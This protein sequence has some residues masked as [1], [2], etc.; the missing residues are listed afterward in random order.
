MADLGQI[1]AWQI[2]AMVF[3]FSAYI[4]NG[5]LLQI[6]DAKSVL[7]TSRS[8]LRPSLALLAAFAMLIVIAVGT[9]TAEQF[10]RFWFFS[11][12]ATSAVLIATVRYT[13]LA[14]VRRSLSKG[15]FFTKALSIGLFCDPISRRDIA[16]GT[17]NKVRVEANFR[18]DKI[19]QLAA[20]ADKIALEGVDE[21]FIAA[22]WGE[23]PSIMDKLHLMQHL[24][25]KVVL[26]PKDHRSRTAKL[27]GAAHLGDWIAFNVIDEPIDPLS[28]WLKRKEDLTISLLSLLVLAPLLALV[29]IAIKLD[30]PGPIIFRQT[31]VGFNGR[32]FELLKFRSMY[33]D[34]RDA[35]AAKQTER[36][37]PRV[38]RVGRFIRRTSIDELPQVI[39]VLAGTMSIV[40]PRP[41]ALMTMTEGRKLEELVEYYAVRHRV[42]P[43]ITGLAQVNGLRGELDSSEKL[44]RRVDYDLEYIECWSLVLDVKIILKTIKTLL[45]NKFT[46]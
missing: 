17:G 40:G 30:S 24:S 45:P 21:V 23:I 32:N 44:R 4:L 1:E 37:D 41:H 26:C 16:L 35:H 13:L 25:T 29:A 5:Q 43:G 39:N 8:V 14:S 31:R 20:L 3:A 19:G 36:D 27:K 42:K 46:Y 18:I 15:A 34:M 2:W 7:L 12:A 33:H 28:S 9:K 38:T 11:W 6:F 22:P 10:S